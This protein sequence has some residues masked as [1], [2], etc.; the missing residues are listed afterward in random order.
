MERLVDAAMRAGAHGM[1]SGLVLP[2][3]LL[4]RHRASSLRLCRVVARYHGIYTSHIRGERETILEAVAEAI[5]IG[6]RAGVAG[7]GLAQRPQVGGAGGRRRQPGTDG[8]G[9]SRGPRRDHRQRCAPE[10]APRL[11]R[12]LPQWVARPRVATRSSRCS[13]IRRGASGSVATSRRTRCR[14]PAIRS[15]P[16]RALRP[17]RDPARRPSPGAARPLGG[18]YRRGARP[19]RLRRLP[20]PHPRGGGRHGRASST[21]SAEDDIRALLR[22]PVA[23]VCSDGLVMP[24]ADDLDDPGLYWPCSYGEYAGV[25]ERYVRQEGR[26][27]PR[28]GRAQDDLLPGAAFRPARPRRAAPRPQGRPRASSTSNA[29]ATGRPTATL[30]A[31]RSRTSRHGT[32]RASTGCSSTAC[33]SSPTAS[34]RERCRAAFCG[35]ADAPTSPERI[36]HCGLFGRALS[37]R[38]WT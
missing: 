18:G 21:T 36:R 8:A 24:P 35:A 9:A 13:P 25:L 30:T 1:S 38:T 12:A 14:A 22:S 29:S 28:G 4:R 37:R 5:E 31:S 2:A 34:T 6:R 17:H 7:G 33:R 26:A 32:P 16:A 19:R 20:R 15:R 23:M 27:A 10:L 3:R 11:S